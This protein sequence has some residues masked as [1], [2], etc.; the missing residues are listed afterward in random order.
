MQF[1]EYGGLSNF[2]KVCTVCFRSGGVSVFLRS[3]HVSVS[4]KPPILVTT[5]HTFLLFCDLR[6]SVPEERTTFRVV[7]EQ[8]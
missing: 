8:L 1:S 5:T 3:L 2:S 4:G 6:F 7:D